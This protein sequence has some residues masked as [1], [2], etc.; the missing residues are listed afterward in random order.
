MDGKDCNPRRSRQKAANPGSKRVV[1]V[2]PLRKKWD[3]AG[4]CRVRDMTRSVTH[5]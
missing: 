2:S 4:H 3:A 5:M 1:D